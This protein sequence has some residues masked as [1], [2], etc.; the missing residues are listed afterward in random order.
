MRAG[1]VL[2]VLQR[3]AW[4]PGLCAA[5]LALLFPAAV[6]ARAAEAMLLAAPLALALLRLPLS[7]SLP[8][9]LGSLP[10]LSASVLGAPVL[11]WLLAAAAA[12]LSRLSPR[13]APAPPPR[14][15]GDEPLTCLL[16]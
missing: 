16:Q 7:V 6:A 3:L 11:L 14:G 5:L 8:P 1:A 9:L 15:A 4:L 2:P 10:V 12:L 13:C